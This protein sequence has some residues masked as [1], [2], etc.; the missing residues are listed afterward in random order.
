MCYWLLATIISITIF[1]LKRFT[2]VNIFEKENE[3][4]KKSPNISKLGVITV[5]GTAI[6]KDTE[7]KTKGKEN[8]DANENGIDSASQAGAT[9]LLN[10]IIRQAVS[11]NHNKNQLHTNFDQPHL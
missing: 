1:I 3:I 7:T 6:K 5:V 11:A 8:I 10:E 9:I 2:N 4:F